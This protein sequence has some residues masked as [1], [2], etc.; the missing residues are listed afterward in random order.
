M[1]H[2]VFDR[3]VEIEF[4]GT[5]LGSASTERDDSLRW[6]EIHI[7]RTEAGNYVIQRLGRSVVYHVT[8]KPCSRGQ[9]VL[10]EL[11]PNSSEPCETCNP[12]V[13][14]DFDFDAS[15]MFVHEVT[16]SSA[17]VVEDPADVHEKLSTFDKDRGV[18]RVS[19][20]AS[21][22]IQDAAAKDPVL[23]NSLIRKR[24]VP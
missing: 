2:T 19:R 17:D 9:E 7:Y 14:E 12:R 23:L 4:E 10:G 3:L 22:A 13:P 1:K 5:R 16:L 8:G 21:R 6:T 24:I 20:V 15:E 18:K 11:I